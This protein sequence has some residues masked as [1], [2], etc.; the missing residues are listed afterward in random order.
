[1]INVLLLMAPNWDDINFIMTFTSP[2]PR[3]N[4]EPII[5]PPINPETD[6]TTAPSFLSILS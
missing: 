1:M 2:I 5:K 3:R 6:P 4:N